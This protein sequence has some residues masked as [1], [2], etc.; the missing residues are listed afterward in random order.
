MEFYIFKIPSGI[1]V[2]S[3][4]RVGWHLGAKKPLTGKTAAASGMLITGTTQSIVEKDVVSHCLVLFTMLFDGQSVNPS[5]SF[6]TC[7]TCVTI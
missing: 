7:C 1:A 4:V 2:S 6:D 3:S 5:E